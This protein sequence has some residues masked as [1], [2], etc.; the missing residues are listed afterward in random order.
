MLVRPGP[1]APNPEDPP[2]FV[3]SSDEIDALFDGLSTVTADD[4]A[5]DDQLYPMMADTA[6]VDAVRGA[7]TE[8]FVYA[9]DPSRRRDVEVEIDDTDNMTA[10]LSAVAALANAARRH[11]ETSQDLGDIGL[12]ARTLI[13]YIGEIAGRSE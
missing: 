2:Q 1:E 3:F 4:I 5:R 10:E 11:A 8:R 12:T 9:N 13:D 6:V 7:A